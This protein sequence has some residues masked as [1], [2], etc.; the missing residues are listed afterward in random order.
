MEVGA[1]LER[2]GDKTDYV[3]NIL[4]WIITALALTHKGGNGAERVIKK[5]KIID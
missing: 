1:D 3:S 4:S 5:G 2:Q